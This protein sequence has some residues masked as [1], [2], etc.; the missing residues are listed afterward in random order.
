MRNKPIVFI[1]FILALV[2]FSGATLATP[3]DDGVEALEQ[4]DYSTA[5]KLFKPLAEAGDQAAQNNLGVLYREGKGVSQNYAEALRWFQR[6]ADQGS[7]WGQYN[8]GMAYEYGFGVS[9]NNQ[10][11]LRWYRLSADQG[12]SAAQ[13]ALGFMYKDGIGVRGNKTEAIKWFKLAAAQNNPTARGALAL[14]SRDLNSFAFIMPS[15]WILV[16]GNAVRDGQLLFRRYSVIIEKQNLNEI[17]LGTNERVTI[18]SAPGSLTNSMIFNCQRDRRKTDFLTV[19]LPDN[20]DPTSFEHQEWVSRLDIRILAD[21]GSQSVQGEYIKG[22]LFIDANAYDFTSEFFRLLSSSRIVFEFG[23]N[24]D[25][26]HFAVSDQIGSA[27]IGAFM[28]EYLSRLPDFAS[29]LRFLSSRDMA[30]LCSTYKRTGRF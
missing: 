8:L 6:S 23:K 10:E 19:H 12:D 28:R 27:N 9:Q 14:L 5:F 29:G 21:G 22:D 4:G 11:A 1:S 24:N 26:I 13:T 20:A 15:F 25:R 7:A 18:I 3:L 16:P 2:C 17:D 30:R